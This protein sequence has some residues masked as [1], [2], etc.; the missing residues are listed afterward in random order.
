M[1]L[2]PVSPTKRQDRAWEDGRS[3]KLHL[4][5]QPLQIDTDGS[6]PGISMSMVKGS[7]SKAKFGCKVLGNLNNEKTSRWGL[8]ASRTNCASLAPD[9][10]DE[11]LSSLSD[12]HSI[13]F[14]L[15]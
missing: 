7:L 11:H 12:H 13:N 5:V 6:R 9:A 15:S 3:C 10:F 14:Y 2:T 1:K 8:L 4:E